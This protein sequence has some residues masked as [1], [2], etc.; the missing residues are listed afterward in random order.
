M[1][2]LRS[3]NYMKWVLYLL[4]RA[5]LKKRITSLHWVKSA[6]IRS[7][8]CVCIFIGLL[9]PRTDFKFYFI[10]IHRHLPFFLIRATEWFVTFIRVYLIKSWDVDEDLRQIF[11]EINL[12]FFSNFRSI[13]VRVWTTR[14]SGRAIRPRCF[15]GT[16]WIRNCFQR[17]QYTSS[18]W[19]AFGGWTV[20]QIC[21]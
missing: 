12:S 15:V 16:D 10:K 20:L 13:L 21:R 3:T 11:N 2:L 14:W 18:S 6:N 17:S 5:L 1:L 7:S 8:C 4:F 9:S 19:Q